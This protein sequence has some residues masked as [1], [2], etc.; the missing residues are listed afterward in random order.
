[1]TTKPRRETC[2]CAKKLAM[3]LC[4]AFEPVGW[5]T[6]NAG[7]LT[8]DQVSN[9]LEVSPE[10]AQTLVDVGL[11]PA[12]DGRVKLADMVTFIE[13]T[14]WL[15]RRAERHMLYLQAELESTRTRRAE[16]AAEVAEEALE[17]AAT[18][19]SCCGTVAP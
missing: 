4:E 19:Q 6:G 9:W 17:A 7:L 1:M 16:V 18:D 10:E 2:G 14:D 11:L 8:V 12:W 3:R 13:Q 15:R 5:N